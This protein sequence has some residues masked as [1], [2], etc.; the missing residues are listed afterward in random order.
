MLSLSVVHTEIELLFCKAFSLFELTDFFEPKGQAPPSAAV[1]VPLL[2]RLL[3]GVARQRSEQA[4]AWS[5]GLR[6]LGWEFL[7]VC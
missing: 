6:R 1:P 5:I 4:F 3:G 7:F 2:L